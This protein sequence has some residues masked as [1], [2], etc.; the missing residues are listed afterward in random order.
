MY[1]FTIL[2][3]NLCILIKSIILFVVLY[4]LRNTMSVETDLQ[5]M[6]KE[7]DSERHMSK[8]GMSQCFALYQQDTQLWQCIK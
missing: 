8:V 4:W 2:L 7:H 1:F 6:L 3:C 5:E